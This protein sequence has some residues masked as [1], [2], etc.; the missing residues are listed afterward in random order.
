MVEA[1]IY[2]PDSRRPAYLD[3][4]LNVAMPPAPNVKDALKIFKLLLA[5]PNISSKKQV[6]SRYDHEVQTRTV[7]KPGEGDAAVLRLKK[8][9][10]GLAVSVDG[11]ARYTYL[12]PY[13][14]GAMAVAEACRNV[15]V[16]GS[17]PIAVTDCLN[18][19]SYTHLTLPTICSV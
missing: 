14:G 8:S 12:N 16:T 5:S 4:L 9:T 6:Y 1:P 3:G 18:S 13:V 19:D 11:N 15:A 10:R 2:Q 7:V 17:T